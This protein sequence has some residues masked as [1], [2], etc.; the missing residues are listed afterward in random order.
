MRPATAV[1]YSQTRSWAP[2][3]ARDLDLALV[4]ARG[5]GSLG[6]VDEPHDLQVGQVLAELGRVGVEHDGQDARALLAGGLGDELL[7]P[8][9]EAD[10]VRA[11]GDDAE[12]VAAAGSVPAIA[13]PSTRPG[14]SALSIASSSSDRLGLVEE[15]RDVDAGEAATARGRRR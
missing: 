8:V 5:S 7:G 13:A 10:D 9:G 6:V 4:D 12:L 11:V 15:L 14:L 1:A 2:R 3:R